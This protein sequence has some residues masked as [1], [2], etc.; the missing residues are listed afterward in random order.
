VNRANPSHSS[1]GAGSFCLWPLTPLPVVVINQLKKHRRTLPEERCDKGKPV[2]RQGRKAKDL[3]EAAELPNSERW[4][5]ME[6]LLSV[7]FFGY[8]EVLCAGRVVPLRCQSNAQTILKCLIINRLHPVSR[9]YLM[10]WLW[11]E[12][13]YKKARWSLNTSIYTL[14]RLLESTLPQGACK[15]LILQE[16]GHYFLAPSIQ[17]WVDTDVFEDYYMQGRCFEKKGRREE[18]AA[19]YQKAIKLYR[20]DYL[21]E[22]LYE[23]WTMIERERLFHIFTSILSSLADYYTRVRLYHESIQTCYR[24][25]QCDRY[26]ENAYALLEESYEGLGLHERALRQRLMLG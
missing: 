8:F 21:I 20:G 17:L 13:S 23:D 10:G 6:V 1:L 15:T 11:P 24:L 3:I 16:Q 9:D 22:D 25:L 26:N 7:R 5:V 12:A 14:R 4:G 2:V 18:A 19:E